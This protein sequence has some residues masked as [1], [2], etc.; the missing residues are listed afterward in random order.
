MITKVHIKGYKKLKD[1][2]FEPRAGMN[3]LVGANDSGKTTVLEAMGLCLNGRINN[4]SAYEA[5]S[6]Y[7]FNL[8]NVEKLF[9]GLQYNGTIIL[10]DLPTIRIDVHLNVPKGAL[11]EL[12]GVNNMLKEDSPGISFVAVPDEDYSEE[13]KAYFSQDDIPQI[14]PV[15]YYSIQ[16]FSFSGGSL[17]K[18]PKGLGVTSIDSLSY[19]SSRGLDYY[20]KQILEE[21]LN[22]GE[23]SSIS[24]EYRKARHGI[25]KSVLEG[26]NVKIREDARQN[27]ST[28]GVI[29]IQVNESK[30]SSWDS[31]IIPSIDGM[32]F[33]M[34]GQG[35]QIVAKTRLSLLGSDELVK[36]I[37][38]EEPE[39]HLSHTRLR[40]LLD[41][42]ESLA[43]NRQVFITTHSPFVLN[44]L[45]LDGLILLSDGRSTKFNSLSEDTIL[46][47]KKISGFDTLR[48]VL[49]D[50]IIIVEGP[51]DEILF[52][53]MFGD[54]TGKTPESLGI[55]VM[56]IGG[57]SFARCFELASKMNRQLYALRDN[58]GESGDYWTDK[59]DNFLDGKK[60]KMYIGDP[61]DGVTL[62]DQ[63]YKSNRMLLEGYSPEE[64]K[65]AKTVTAIKIASMNVDKSDKLTPPEYIMKA[66]HDL[67]H[68]YCVENGEDCNLCEDGKNA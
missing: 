9:K 25:T 64:M 4:Q 49:A 12:R 32:P 41:I 40:E 22:Y 57:T 44:R 37:F 30:T 13:I 24:L 63:V 65:K 18:T 33:S 45:G 42:I 3:I 16:R 11:Q 62:E 60:I 58:D 8:E 17:S 5:L 35:S 53:R 2:T 68:M 10:E 51:S 36:F 47:Y 19:Y 26:I 59:I 28:R 1:F 6:P 66:I 21:K 50:K 54:Q 31:A 34:A 29:G 43:G 39:N 61:K 67:A 7:W 48:L 52:N 15:E 27:N 55:D 56:S 23:R 14:I 20:T 38:L 46:Y